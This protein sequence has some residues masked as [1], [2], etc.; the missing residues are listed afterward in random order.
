MTHIKAVET[1]ESYLVGN[2]ELTRSIIEQINSY[3]SSL[4]H[5]RTYYNENYFFNTFFKDNPMG[6]IISAQHGDY[7]FSDLY[8]M[9]DGYENLVSLDKFAYKKLIEDN[10]EEII[11]EIKEHKRQ[12]KI[13]DKI[14][15][16]LLENI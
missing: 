7:R 6:A 12:L 14:F 8:V 5:L 9:F 11:I 16:E 10:I 2:T 3:N 13:K 15:N 1:L 4:E